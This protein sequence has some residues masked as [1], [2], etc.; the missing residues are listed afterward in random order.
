MSRRD[1]PKH[2]SL[3][4]A[5][6]QELLDIIDTLMRKVDELTTRVRTLED[7]NADLRRQLKSN[8]KNSSRPPS[9]DRYPGKKNATTSQGS[10]ETDKGTKRNRGA[11]PGHHGTQ[12]ALV[13]PNRVD[14]T[15]HCH[16]DCCRHCGGAFSSETISGDPIR[17]QQ[18]DCPPPPPTIVEYQRFAHCCPH[19]DRVTRGSLPD[20]VIDSAFGPNVHAIVGTLIGTCHLSHRQVADVIRTMHGIPMSDGV[21]AQIQKRISEQLSPIHEEAKRHVEESEVAH[22]DETGWRI[23]GQ[24]AWV[25]LLTNT[26]LSV[27]MIQERRNADAADTL[28][29]DFDGVLVTDRCPSY[30]VYEGRRQ[31]CWAH[32]IRDFAGMALYTRRA[33]DLGK[34]LHD[35]ALSLFHH[36]HRWKDG[37]TKRSTFLHHGNAIRRC[38]T[39]LLEQG[40]QLKNPC[41]RRKCKKLRD[42]WA[43]AWTFLESPDIPPTN[44]LAEQSIR[45]AVI[46]RKISYGSQSQGGR[47]FTERIMTVAASCR[48]QSRSVLEFMRQVFGATEKDSPPS[49]VQNP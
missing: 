9:S 5:S 8:S 39:D 47:E 44:N 36:H 22:A 1:P 11:Q 18:W 12:R 13:D 4:D 49:L 31:W 25:W 23:A 19:C 40:M 30:N 10:Q 45:P 17:H 46:S 16:P 43:M 24:R 33:G 2:V 27:F 38:M 48:K 34:E 35:Q 21:V 3:A 37:K 29:G 7:E 14:R 26:L 41:F 28:L 20:D 32:L 6:R 15:V 42:G